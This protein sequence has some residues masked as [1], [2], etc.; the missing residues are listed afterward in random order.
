MIK[1]QLY[2]EQ[3]SGSKDFVRLDLFDD[4]TITLVSSIQ[5]VKDIAKIFAD[6]SR[7]FKVPANDINNKFFKHFYNPDIVGYDANLKRE[8]KIYLNHQPYREGF[9]YLDSIEMKNN[10]PSTYTVIFYGGLI[11]LKD[12]IR[13]YKLTSLDLS[14]YNHDYTASEV[15]T[16]FTN[17]SGLSS[18]N[19]IY[20]LI[21]PK[22]RLYYDSSPSG[23]NYDGNLYYDSADSTRGLS[24]TDLKPAIKVQRIL[25]AIETRFDISFSGFFDTT[26]MS[27]L[28]LWLSREGNDIVEY[29][30]FDEETEKIKRL[31]DT[32]ATTDT[33]TDPQLNVSS[34]GQWNF[35]VFGLQNH[36][37]RSTLNLTE[38]SNT[39]AIITLRIVDTN[40]GNVYASKQVTGSANQ[41]FDTGFIYANNYSR[42]YNIVWE[43]ISDAAIT[44]KSTVKVARHARLGAETESATYTVN[45]GAAMT[46]EE[47]FEINKHLPDMR[48]MDFLSGLFRMFNLTAYVQQPV[49]STPIIEV[50][51]LDD[52]YADAANNM[53]K[54]TIDITDFVDVDSHTVSPARPFTKVSFEYEETDTVLMAQHKAKFDKIFGNS[55]YEELDYSDIGTT[56]E[57]K[58]PFS[59]LKYERLYDKSDNSLTEIQWGYAA[60]GDF[61]HEELTPPKGNYSSV[62]IKPLLFYGI[63]ETITGGEDISW[64]SGTHDDITTY[65]RPSNSNEE[66]SISNAPAFNLNFDSEF[67]EWNRIDYRDFATDGTVKDNSLFLK[68]YR[69]YILSVFSDKKRL[70]KYKCFLPAKILTQ[71]KLNDQVRIQD[72]VFRINSIK[73]NLNTGATELELLNLIP[74]IDTII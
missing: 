14:E 10:K 42:T 4:E 66:G 1:I 55:Y 7:T 8:A 69:N 54:G 59:H 36:D 15:K 27:N 58:L 21:T 30:G 18:A 9:I 19:I 65:W 26:P 17:S 72:R 25:D 48:I 32:F 44:F 73:T 12:K 47:T 37:Y 24:Y 16:G 60:G 3:T 28:Y 56:Y 34:D 63:H 6:F 49:A 35:F 61:K 5:D 20:P 22:K 41:S 23:V 40:T 43:V 13:D 29:E 45:G 64:I 53:S 57:I 2:V 67:D 46:T 70:Y 74:D 39:S 11:I 50:E 71:Y 68:Y 33:F 51:T 52:Y 31:D 62:N 38:I